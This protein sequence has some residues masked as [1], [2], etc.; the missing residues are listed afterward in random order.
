[1]SQELDRSLR[2]SHW[3]VL[4]VIALCAVLSAVQP[5]HGDDNAPGTAVTGAA[6]A[7]GLGSILA[8]GAS[9]SRVIASRT[10]VTLLLCAY[11]C[12][13]GL[14]VLGTFVAMTLGQSQVGLMFSLA[15]GIFSLRRPPTFDPNDSE[16]T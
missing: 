15:A 9:G 13:T 7:L 10:R 5:G 14:A 4:A 11:A 12:A 2:T 16:P 6:L 8:R 1:M 3:T